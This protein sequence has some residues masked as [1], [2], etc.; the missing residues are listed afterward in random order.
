MKYAEQADVRGE[1]DDQQ[2]LSQAGAARAM[3]PRGEDLVEHDRAAEQ[4]D[5]APVPPAVEDEARGDDERP[6]ERARAASSARR[7]AGRARRRARTSSSGRAPGSVEP[8]A[9]SFRLRRPAVASPRGG[10]P[11]VRRG[12]PRG[13][14]VLRLVRRAARRGARAA[15]AAEDGH[16]APVRR[17]R[18]D[19][20]RRAARP[21]EPARAPS[22]A[23]SRRRKAVIER[24][25]GTVEKFIGDAV[26]AVF[27]V[28]VVHEDDALRAVRAAAGIREAIALLNEELAR[29]YGT[30]LDAA[31]RR[32]HGRGRHRDGR[33]PRHRRRRRRRRPARAGGAAGRDPARRGDGAARARLGRGRSRS[34]TS[35][36]RARREPLPALPP[37]RGLGARRRSARTTRRSWAGS[38]SG[39][40][41]RG[42]WERARAER[43]ATSS[44]SSARPASASHGL[45]RS[46]CP[47][48]A[49]TRASCAGR[50]LS[51]GEGITYWPVVE[52]LK[53]LLGA[54]AV[55]DARRARP[56]RGR[57]G[58]AARPAR[59]RPS[60]RP[61]RSSSPGRCGSCSRPSPRRRPLVVVLDDLQWAEPTL[62]DLVEHVADLS[63]DAPILLLC[64]ARPGPARPAARLGR[65]QAE[66]DHGAARAAPGGR[67]ERL[68]DALLEGAPL[69]G[70]VRA[71]ILAAADG[72]PLFVEEMLA[73]IR[74]R[75]D[76]EVDVPPSIQALLAARL[77]QLDPSERDVLERGSVEGKVFHR[78][79]V[80]ALAP[81]EPRSRTRL[82]ALV[83]KELVRPDRTQL[84]GD[85]AYRFRHLLIRDAAYEALPKSDAR[86]AA[87]ALRRLARSSD[88]ADLVELDEILGYHLE[89]AY[90]Y[91]A[92][93]GPADD[94][95]DRLA[96][97]ARRR[98]IAAARREQRARRRRRAHE[99]ARAGRRALT[100]RRGV[101][102]GCDSSSLQHARARATTKARPSWRKQVRADAEAAGDGAWSCS[103]GWPSRSGRCGPVS[104]VRPLRWSASPTKRSR[105][106]NA[107][108]ITRRSSTRGNRRRTSRSSTVS[109]KPSCVEPTGTRPRAAGGP[110]RFGALLPRQHRHGALLR[111]D[112]GR[113]A[114]SWYDEHRWLEPVGP[115]PRSS[116]PRCS[117][118]SA[119]STRLAPRPSAPASGSW[120]WG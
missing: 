80:Q 19:R 3:D 70:D 8:S 113:E 78:G 88:G 25:G 30:T 69:D 64:L 104:K 65:R 12:E 55:G 15:R 116:L 93:L 82:V 61:R 103:P 57:R 39:A 26:L 101:G 5:E 68:I 49:T 10:L 67:C 72:N 107:T 9:A 46:S 86:R 34:S 97:R 29:D 63:R 114:I 51:Y 118:C 56:R 17:D 37:A 13:S 100:A 92:E 43:A 32:Q 102:V 21:G 38:A 77:D 14:A 41:S 84:P 73:L 36:R 109:T 58:L 48:S 27:G 90:R 120:N 119:V 59:R 24:H 95:A 31:D 44:P 96:D 110:S 106:S 117:H 115:D 91:R 35:R 23:T 74:E 105:S 4:E 89:Q 42:A 1:G 6:P 11:G 83:R 50:C 54:T 66:R 53:Q 108:A 2:P 98:L 33:A 112:A 45:R 75:G 62:L 76:G 20:A 47:S 28:P 85:D 111:A 16:G 40:C 52:I 87:R 79:A 22:P 94:R 18:L 81:D 99:L 71:R 60:S 7:A